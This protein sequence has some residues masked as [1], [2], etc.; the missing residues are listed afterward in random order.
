MARISPGCSRHSKCHRG[1]QKDPEKDLLNPHFRAPGQQLVPLSVPK[2]PGCTRAKLLPAFQGLSW[3]LQVPH[4]SLPAA[5]ESTAFI[6]KYPMNG[7]INSILCFSLVHWCSASSEKPLL[8]QALR[9]L[10]WLI[11]LLDCFWWKR[12]RHCNLLVFLMRKRLCVG[13]NLRR[14]LRSITVVVRRGECCDFSAPN[15]Q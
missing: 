11:F 5:M 10:A 3:S 8:M 1:E 12:P 6:L 14:L 4:G 9:V 15:T 2:A 13:V 7:S